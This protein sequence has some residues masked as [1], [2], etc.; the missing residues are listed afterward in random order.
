MIGH[1]PIDKP[2]FYYPPTI[3]DC[4][5]VPDAD[6]VTHALF[7]P[8]LSVLTLKDEAEAIPLANGTDYALA[9][10]I[11][12]QNL[13][14][15]HRVTR[16]LRSGVVWLNTWRVVSPLAPF[17]GY[18]KSGFGPESGIEAALEYTTTKTVWLRTSD[19]PIYD[20]FIMR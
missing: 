13:T 15:A 10:G 4:S 3:L 1:Q 7:G 6:S 20:P 17:G 2:G 18:G 12:T 5:S 16:R 19:E 14:L 11:F 9:A 8:V